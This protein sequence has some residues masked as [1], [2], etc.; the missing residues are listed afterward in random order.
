M[1][2]TRLQ[3]V[4]LCAE[5]I[6]STR[7]KVTVGNQLSGYIKFHREIKQGY[8]ENTI[9]VLI[10]AIPPN[11]Y[12]QVHDLIEHGGI[13]YCREVA[14]HLLVEVGQRIHTAGEVADITVVKSSL[15]DHGYLHVS[16]QLQDEKTPSV[17]EIDAWDPRIIDIS[18]RPDGSIKNRELLD[19]GYPALVYESVSSNALDYRIQ[20]LFT[21]TPKPLE[22]QAEGRCTPV[23]EMLT[24]HA[25]LYSDHTLDKALARKKIPPEGTLHYLQK[26]SI[27]QKAAPQEMPKDDEPLSK[28]RR[29]NPRNH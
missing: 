8:F 27:W 12:V 15:I 11:D 16:L 19:Y 9:R 3:F 24:K 26:V 20:F 13:G 14:W 21:D 1:P 5:A 29:L 18:P 23:S 7:E 2:L 10:D 6:A 25:A 4:E 22:G 28:K 17:W